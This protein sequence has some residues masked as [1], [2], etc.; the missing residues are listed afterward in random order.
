MALNADN[1]LDLLWK[2]YKGVSPTSD[3]KEPHNEQF[4]SNP[5][6]FQQNFWTDSDRLPIPAPN[7]ISPTGNELWYDVIQPRINI[8]SVRMVPDPTSNSAWVAV[9]AFNSGITD[10]NRLTNW[11]PDYFNRTYSIRVWAGNPGSANFAPVRLYPNTTNEEWV[12]DYTTG[13]LY[14]VN[15]VPNIAVQ[16]GIWIE[17]WLYTGEIGRSNQ[18]S[19]ASNTSKIRTLTFT[20]GILDPNAFA[21]FTLQTGGKAVLVEAKVDTLATLEC[22]ATSSR[23]DTNPYRFISIA[24]HLVDDGSYVVSGNRFY[25]ERFINLINMQDTTSDVTYWRVYNNN[26]SPSIITVIVKVA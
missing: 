2:K 6:G 19:G 4:L 12:F 10:A 9:S 5:P 25:G 8:N 13:V 16:Q 1:K 26:V 22:H 24:S 14:F 21:D 18:N 15:N 11:V 23:T 17:G 7:V 20:T 3:F